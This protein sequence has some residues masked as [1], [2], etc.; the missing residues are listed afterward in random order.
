[1]HKTTDEQMLFIEKF[2]DRSYNGRIDIKGIN[3]TFV[4]EYVGVASYKITIIYK[5]E[6]LDIWIN[7]GITKERMI[8]G[9]FDIVRTIDSFLLKIDQRERVNFIYNILTE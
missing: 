6:E 5:E 4:H 1:M 2:I 8:E 9:L 3:L 7:A